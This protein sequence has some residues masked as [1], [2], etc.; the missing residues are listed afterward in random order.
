ML[1]L[2]MA[3]FHPDLIPSVNLKESQCL[4]D[5]HIWTGP[6][7]VRVQRI[8]DDDMEE[9]DRDERHG[10]VGPLTPPTLPG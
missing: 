5:F 8:R 10:S 9:S 7:F 4:P 2:S 3:A 1:E 6:A